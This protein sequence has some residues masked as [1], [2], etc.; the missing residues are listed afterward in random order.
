MRP[1]PS[2]A[3][4][5]DQSA[6]VCAPSHA[7]TCLPPLHPHVDIAQGEAELRP[8]AT[9]PQRGWRVRYSRQDTWTAGTSTLPRL[10][11]GGITG[12][13]AIGAAGGRWVAE[14]TE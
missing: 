4:A 10:V 7:S 8:Q 12:S 1:A 6:S 13:S 2:H 11:R 3:P 5:S 9:V 14:A